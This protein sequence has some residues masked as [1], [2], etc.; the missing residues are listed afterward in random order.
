MVQIAKARGAQ[1]TAV[2]SARN[3]A[4]L[5]AQGADVAIDY[6]TTD[7]R[8]L[9]K[10]FDVIADCPGKMPYATHRHLLKKGGRFAMVTGTMAEALMTPLIN[11]IRPHRIIGGTSLATK[12]GLADIL[13]LHAAGQI[14]P[15]IDSSYP[16]ANIAEA[17]AHV[18]KGHKRGNTVI[19]F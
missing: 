15:V 5:Q 2:A 10:P 8:R 16:L 14:S 19:T 11:L 18:D 9:S 13:D 12:D 4:F 1:V 7:L 17:H 6:T 3:H